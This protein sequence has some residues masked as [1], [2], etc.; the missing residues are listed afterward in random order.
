MRALPSSF[1]LTVVLAASGIVLAGQS[2][3]RDYPQWRGQHRDGAASGFI[4]PKSWPS[5]L[6]RRWKVEVG[7]GYATPLVIGDTVYVFT[8]RDENEG[9]TALSART[10]EERW[11]SSYPAPYSPSQ[12]TA[13]HGAGP[14]AT[15]LYQEGKLFTL[16]ISGIVSG[17]DAAT[18]KRLW[19]TEPPK[20]PPYF[21]AASSPLGDKGLVIVHPGDYG[22]LT[23]FD[24]GT[25]DVKWTAGG[26]G[27]FASPIIIELGGTRQIVSATQD[28][29]IAVSPDGRVLWRY[30]WK[31]SNG[32]TTPILNGDTIIV[33]SPEPGV[34]ALRPTMRD[35]TWSVTTVW[36]TKEVSM[37]VSNPVVVADTLFGLS[38][39]ARGQFF[40]LDAK[41]GAVLWL[42]QS[43]EAENTALVKA[44]DLL[45]LLNDDAELIVA[46]A[47]R[48]AFTAIARYTVAESA[49][50]AQPAISG[51]RIFVKDVTSLSLWT[52]D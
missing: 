48:S 15:P 5:A 34:L 3:P 25:G 19:Q 18:G 40:A 6:T 4:A 29:V 31:G 43:R 13:I 27:F 51:N 33:S 37:Y 24:T 10:G 38:T 16:G 26:G 32:G 23:A 47:S 44:G 36:E 8:R 22:P 11:R 9:L 17:F 1:V 52:I 28:S 35:G 12:P 20:E 21:S 2:A 14:K 41:T 49:T 46:R 30:P 45:F 7:D 39:K 50:W 42:G